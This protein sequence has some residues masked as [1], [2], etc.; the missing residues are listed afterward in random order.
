[1]LKEVL[2]TGLGVAS[3]LKERVEAE[4]KSLEEKGKINKEDAK[5]FLKSLEEKGKAEDEK[6]KARFKEL[7]KEA[8]DELGLATKEDLAK[9]KEE[10]K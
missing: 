5:S 4:M 6:I 10:L 1:M 7:L 9:L 2:F 3:V 8:V